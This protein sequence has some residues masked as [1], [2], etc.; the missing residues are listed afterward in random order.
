LSFWS[1][2]GSDAL[3]RVIDAGRRPRRGEPWRLRGAGGHSAEARAEGRAL[4]RHLRRAAAGAGALGPTQWPQGSVLNTTSVL[5]GSSRP[6]SN[7]D[8]AYV[9]HRRLLIH[10]SW[11]TS[12]P[13]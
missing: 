7:S 5:L 11:N 4:R 6:D 10:C 2:H 1:F 8:R 13:R 9:N 3:A 12:L